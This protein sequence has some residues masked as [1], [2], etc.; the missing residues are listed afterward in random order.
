MSRLNQP[1]AYKPSAVY[2]ILSF[3]LSLSLYVI[4]LCKEILSGFQNPA[5]DKPG[6]FRLYAQIDLEFVNFTKVD[7]YL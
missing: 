5:R 3:S 1:F 4:C 7:L 2:Y 6:F